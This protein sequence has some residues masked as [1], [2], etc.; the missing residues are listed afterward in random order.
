MTIDDMIGY[1]N[2]QLPKE[3]LL[4]QLAEEATGLAQAAL[5]L[6]RAIDGRNY[7]PVTPQGAR[8]GLWSVV[9][10]L[11]EEINDVRVCLMVPGLAEV[12]ND[13]AKYMAQAKLRRWAERLEAM[14]SGK[15]KG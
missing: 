13:D 4:A 11:I 7:T 1:I 5:K 15:A 3:E 8:C 12:P 14:G 2:R 9:C 10:G 6:R